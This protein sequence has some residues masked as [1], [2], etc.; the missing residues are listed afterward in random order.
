MKQIRGIDDKGGTH[1]YWRGKYG[2]VL[3]R[4]WVREIC[5]SDEAPLIP[6]P[7][8]SYKQPG[9]HLTMS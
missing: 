1:A 9:A 7:C 3:L 6:Y 4:E 5:N 2:E 8:V